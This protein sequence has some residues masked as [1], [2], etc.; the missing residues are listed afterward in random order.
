SQY[1]RQRIDLRVSQFD[2]FL[3]REVKSLP[4]GPGNRFWVTIEISE[5]IRWDLRWLFAELTE[6]VQGV[7]TLGFSP[8]LN[9]L[10]FAIVS[11]RPN[12]RMHPVIRNQF[13]HRNVG[14]LRKKKF[15]KMPIIE[16]R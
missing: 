8:S 2:L 14:A 7:D 16:I 11:R 15:K 9:F 10:K 4:C 12:T 6:E 13:W 5:H 1:V 3:N